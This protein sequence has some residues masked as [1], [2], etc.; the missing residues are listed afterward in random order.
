MWQWLRCNVLRRHWCNRCIVDSTCCY[1]HTMVPCGISHETWAVE[2]TFRLCLLGFSSSSTHSLLRTAHFTSS[3]FVGFVD[4]YRE[5]IVRVQT[6]HRVLACSHFIS[7]YRIR[8]IVCFVI[9]VRSLY[10]PSLSVSC[11]CCSGRCLYYKGVWI[12]VCI[13]RCHLVYMYIIANRL[14]LQTFFL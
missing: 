5:L 4:N 10:A 13:V 3:L 1:M 14:K 2:R 8:S 11:K 6:L 7:L 12:S 9:V